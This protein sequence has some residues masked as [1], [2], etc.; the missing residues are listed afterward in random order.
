MLFDLNVL[1]R[2]PDGGWDYNNAQEIIDFAKS[3]DVL[4]DWQLGNGNHFHSI[5]TT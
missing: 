1:I 3:R 4:L 5:A 2:L